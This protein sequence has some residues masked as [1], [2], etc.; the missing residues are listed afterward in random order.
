MLS[1]FW[2][3]TVFLTHMLYTHTTHTVCIDIMKNISD[4]INYSLTSL[5]VGIQ[6][7]VYTRK[8][9]EEKH[10]TETKKDWM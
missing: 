2:C 4:G 5:G 1:M 7:S 8:K 3:S 6:N 10:R 9:K